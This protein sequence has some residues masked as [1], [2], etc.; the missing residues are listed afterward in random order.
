M[1][2]LNNTTYTLEDFDYPLPH[3]LIA[4]YPLAQRDQSR[5]LVLNRE[6]GELAHHGFAELVNWIE[7]G[8]L[9]VFNNAKVIPARLLG[10]RQGHTGKVEVF[11]LH[12][13]NEAKTRWQVLMRPSRKLPVGTVVTFDTS[14]LEVHIQDRGENGLGVVDLIWPEGI[15]LEEILDQTGVLPIPPYMERETE[16]IDTER[17]QTVYAKVAGA[18]AAPTAGLHFTE[19]ILESLR[20]K[21]ANL[22][23]VTLHVSAGTFRPVQTPTIGEHKMDAEYYTVSPETA[24][25]IQ[26]TKAAGKRVI[27]VGTTVTKTLETS[28]FRNQGQVTAESAWSE[29][30]ITPGFQFQV[31]DSLLTNFHLPKSTLLMLVSAFAGRDPIMHAYET[32]VENQYRFYSYGDCMLIQ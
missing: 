4:K 32:A 31:I 1:S 2:L 13:Q 25:A 9:V 18:Q 3:A 23:E 22:A 17:Y 14:P 7:P 16:A 5:M 29:L 20:A 15:M 12:P 8:D 10:H 28:A 11:L 24:E 30:F 6:S 19:D 21:G 27:A 26:A